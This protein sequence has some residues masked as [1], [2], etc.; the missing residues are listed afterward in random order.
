METQVNR[1]CVLLP[2]SSTEHW[3]VPQNCLA[4][5]VTLTVAEDET[6]PPQ[7]EWRGQTV[8]VLDLGASDQ[9]SWRESQGRTGLIAIFLGL[10]GEGLNFWG[11]ALRGSGLGTANL[12]ESDIE[13]YDVGAS[14][15]HSAAFKIEDKVYKV[16]DL[17]ALQQRMTE[18]FAE[19]A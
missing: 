17:F 3:A 1:H 18:S 13:D 6:P 15:L 4:E 19:M 5:I 12:L 10:E 16:P 8:P 2:C 11:L 9:A 14:E 7:I